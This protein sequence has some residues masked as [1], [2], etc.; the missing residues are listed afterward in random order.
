M[1]LQALASLLLVEDNRELFM[2]EEGSVIGLV[3]LLD[4]RFPGVAKQF[5][6]AA[7]QPL[8]G[9]AKCRKQMMA[10]GVCNHLYVL[11]DMEITGA[12][13]LLDRLATGKL[14]SIIRRT[15]L[16]ST[17]HPGFS[18]F[19]PILSSGVTWYFSCFPTSTWSFM[20]HL[21]NT[22][23]CCFPC[24]GNAI[25]AGQC[26]HRHEWCGVFCQFVAK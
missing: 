25:C 18:P 21:V 13:R 15:L 12:K 7:L 16:V 19:L 11:A 17:N 1:S 20:E 23:C 2:A 26:E 4:T 22:T 9:N 5:P 24:Y 3:L 10:A 14:R 8:A 6:I